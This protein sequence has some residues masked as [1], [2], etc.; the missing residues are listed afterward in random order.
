Q[1]SQVKSDVY[2]EALNEEV[3]ALADEIAGLWSLELA[4]A[5]RIG[6]RATKARELLALD[7]CPPWMEKKTKGTGRLWTIFCERATLRGG[8]QGNRAEVTT[9]VPV[10][11]STC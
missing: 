5:F 3:G 2:K 11:P 4:A 10:P 8:R 1:V 6:E 7:N 9:N